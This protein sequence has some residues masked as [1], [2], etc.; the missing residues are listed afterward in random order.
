MHCVAVHRIKANAEII[1]LITFLFLSVACGYEFVTCL[2][3]GFFAVYYSHAPTVFAIVF[4]QFQGIFFLYS[5]SF[6]NFENYFI[7]FEY[8]MRDFMSRVV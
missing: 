3:Y 5:T 2:N 7:P 4:A 1:F 8:Q 6:S